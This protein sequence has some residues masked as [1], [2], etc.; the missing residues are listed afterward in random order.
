MFAELPFPRTAAACKEA[1][2]REPSVNIARCI[3]NANI[4]TWRNGERVAWTILPP[5]FLLLLGVL[6]GWAVSGFRS[7]TET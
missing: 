7:G 4:E 5:V 3:E 2:A 1:A 6:I